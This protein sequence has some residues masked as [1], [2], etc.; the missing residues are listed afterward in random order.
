MICGV[1]PP[2]YAVACTDQ[3]NRQ[4]HSQDFVD[5]LYQGAEGREDIGVVLQGFG[6]EVALISGI[7]VQ[8]FGGIVLAKASLLNRIFSPVI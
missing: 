4:V 7:V 6:K 2:E 1:I 3:V 8:G 5:F